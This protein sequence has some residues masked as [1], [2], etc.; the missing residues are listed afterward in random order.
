MTKCQIDS[1]ELNIAIDN[2]FL[3]F[4]GLNLEVNFGLF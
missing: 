2:T 3:C 4:N 1:M